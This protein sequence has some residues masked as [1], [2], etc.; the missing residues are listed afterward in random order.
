MRIRLLSSLVVLCV[1][2]NTTMTSTFHKAEI[3]TVTNR[4]QEKQKPL[5]VIHYNI[6]HYKKSKST[7]S[8]ARDSQL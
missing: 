2:K 3:Q 5:C 6:I 4:K 7:T 1:I 8:H